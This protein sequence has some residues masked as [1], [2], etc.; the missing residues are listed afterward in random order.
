MKPKRTFMMALAAALAFSA[1]SDDSTSSSEGRLT[2]M[3]TDAPGDLAGAFVKIS[4]IVLIRNSAD[5]VSTDSTKRVTITPEVTGY[6]N[7]LNLSGG[8]LLSLVNSKAVPEGTYSQVRI[9]VDQAYVQLKD[10]SYIATT[11]AALPAGVTSSGTLKCPSCSQSGYKVNFSN[12]GLTISGNTTVTLDFDAHQSFAHEA[13]KSGQW[14]MSPVLRAT[15]TTIKLGAIKGTVTL[16]N[17]VTLPACGGAASSVSQFVPLAIMGT[18]TLSGTTS[19]TGTYRLTTVNAG[20]YT[21]SYA[22]DLTFTNGDSLTVT[23]TPS[24]ATTAVVQ[25]DST[26]VNYSVTAASCH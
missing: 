24:A 11:G 13:G 3:L 2:V 18:D 1:C 17:G 6:I 4:K 20:T 12:G 25:G 9:Y 14:I 23:A 7:L 10:G 21:L 8:Q 22:K 5:S 19:T 26:T 16:V 15:A